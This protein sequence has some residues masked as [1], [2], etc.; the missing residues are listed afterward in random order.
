MHRGPRIAGALPVQYGR[1]LSEGFACT[2][3]KTCVVRPSCDQQCAGEC[4]DFSSDKANCGACGHVCPDSCCAGVCTS[5]RTDAKNCGACGNACSSPRTQCT[6]GSCACPLGETFCSGSCV[7]LQTDPLNCSACGKACDTGGI[8]T[9]GV[10]GCPS[11][12]P[13]HCPGACVDEKTDPYNCGACGNKCKPGA[14]CVAGQC[15]CPSTSTDCGTVCADLKSDP[16]NCGACGSACPAPPSGAPNVGATCVSSHCGL[17]CTATHIDCD[18]NLSNGCEGWAPGG[19]TCS[20]LPAGCGCNSNEQCVWTSS[21]SQ[22]GCVATGSG[23]AMSLCTDSTQCQRGFFCGY[24]GTSQ[25]LCV[26]ACASESDCKTNGT[27]GQCKPTQYS[28]FSQCTRQCNPLAPTT[29]DGSHEACGPNQRCWG[30]GKSGATECT[31]LNLNVGVG[32]YCASPFD[33]AAGLTCTSLGSAGHC[34]RYCR[35][36]ID[37]CPNGACRA[38]DSDEHDGATALGYC[39]P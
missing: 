25:G 34:Y 35:I 39:P 20:Q 6:S 8:C 18:K 31:T 14:D 22:P 26:Q 33:C 37:T 17:A 15:V 19:G 24:T 5:T 16:N 12:L 3:A 23:G 10:C 4:L 32:G 36:G 21:M 11:T 13:D 28:G 7:S 2:A 27:Y 30:P 1:K 38:N 29:A 9:A